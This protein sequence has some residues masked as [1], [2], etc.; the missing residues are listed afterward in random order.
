M[1]FC[2]N[3]FKT[4]SPEP[5][6]CPKKNHFVWS[7]ITRFRFA[8]LFNFFWQLAM[9]SWKKVSSANPFFI[10]DLL[11]FFCPCIRPKV[12]RT[13]NEILWV[14]SPVK[15]NVI[16]SCNCVNLS[17]SPLCWDAGNM[18]DF[19]VSG[20]K[21]RF[22]HAMWNVAAKSNPFDGLLDSWSRGIHRIPKTVALTPLL[23]LRS[24]SREN[25]LP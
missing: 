14:F 16:S 13:L 3:L 7:V 24:H 20:A 5:A 1:D 2:V 10:V 12:H 25:L 23:E 4:P 17:I 11:F 18:W 22:K 9:F 6:R 8:F 19:N 15:I 21:A